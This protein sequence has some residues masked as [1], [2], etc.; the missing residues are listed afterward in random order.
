[1]SLALQHIPTGARETWTTP[2]PHAMLTDRRKLLASFSTCAVLVAAICFL[3]APSAPSESLLDPDDPQFRLSPPSSG[4][5]Y[6]VWDPANNARESHYN[7]VFQRGGPFERD[8]KVGGGR[9]TG[10]RRVYRVGNIVLGSSAAAQHAYASIISAIKIAVARAAAAHSVRVSHS[11]TEV[12]YEMSALSSREAELSA[13]VSHNLA[14][15]SA[16]IDR[17]ATRT[18]VAL[19][20]HAHAIRQVRRDVNQLGHDQVVE[21]HRFHVLLNNQHALERIGVAALAKANSVK[22]TALRAEFDAKHAQSDV[23]RVVLPRILSLQRSHNEN[24]AY[25]LQLAHSLLKTNALVRH[26]V[27][28]PTAHFRQHVHAL[29][30]LHVPP[31]TRCLPATRQP[32]NQLT[33]CQVHDLSFGD[34][35]RIKADI[36]SGSVRQDSLETLISLLSK[37]TDQRFVKVAK[38][39]KQQVITSYACHSRASVPSTLTL[40]RRVASWRA[41]ISAWTG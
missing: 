37:H 20:N 10:S 13:S 30:T 26:L 32:S 17:L 8:L 9:F 39:I 27:H 5:Y 16:R 31:H 19:V 41:Y 7:G 6:N 3:S 36:E 28:A 4:E 33:P 40:A 34:M 18:R 14:S 22:G 24:V 29:A 15:Q 21:D 2:S 38:E 12:S 35:E 23:S 25:I 11:H 1:V